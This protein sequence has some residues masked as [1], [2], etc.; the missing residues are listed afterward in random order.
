MIS[1]KDSNVIF[2]IVKT[3]KN[4][5]RCLGIWKY[6]GAAENAELSEIISNISMSLSKFLRNFSVKTNVS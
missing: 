1:L 5:K 4:Q 2:I 6:L 3:K